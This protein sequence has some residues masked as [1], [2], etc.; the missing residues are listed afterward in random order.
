[1]SFHFLPAEEADCSGRTCSG[2][3]PSAPSRLNGTA[4]NDYSNDSAKDS[5]PASQSGM[6]SRPLTGDPGVDAWISSLAGSLAP[7][8][9]PPERVLELRAPSPVFGKRWPEYVATFDPATCGLKT[10][11]SSPGAGWTL[12]SGTLPRWGSM[13]CGVLFRLPTPE[14]LRSESAYGFWPTPQAHDQAKGNPDRVGRFG[15]AHGGRNLNDEAAMWPT[16]RSSDGNGTGAHGDGGMD[17]R[18]AAKQDGKQLSPDWVE[19]LLGWPPG[20]TH[21]PPEV[22]LR[23]RAEAR[24]NSRGSRPAHAKASK[25]APKESGLSETVKTRGHSPSRGKS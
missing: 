25:T 14:G 5:S 3:E 24:I 11:P 8:S 21:L 2:G 16:A 10:P 9:P 23:L 6:T 20:W 1:M 12:F 13:R 19:I 17:L 4:K 18:T 22:V 7:T 15:T